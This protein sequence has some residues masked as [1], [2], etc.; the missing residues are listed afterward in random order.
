MRAVPTTPQRSGA[1]QPTPMACR[2]LGHRYRFRAEGPVM[3]WT[4]ERG[5]DA[6]GRKEYASAA[7]AQHFAEAFDREDRHDIGRRAPLL[8]LLPLRLWYRWKRSRGGR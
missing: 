4:C 5:C 2:V 3:T 7:Q 8:G 6:G 1:D